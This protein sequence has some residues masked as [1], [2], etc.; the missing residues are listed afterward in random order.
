MVHFGNVYYL[1][2]LYYLR[3]GDFEKMTNLTPELLDGFEKYEEEMKPERKVTMWY[4]LMICYFLKGDFTAALHWIEKKLLKDGIKSDREDIVNKCKL[5]NLLVHYEL[6]DT[7]DFES[8]I[9]KVKHSFKK[10]DHSKELIY[11]VTGLMNT[12]YKKHP[13]S[14]KDFDAALKEFDKIDQ[15][16]NK[17]L[18]YDEIEIWLKSKVERQSMQKIAEQMFCH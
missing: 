17:S 10:V 6:E 16:K 14:R 2:F 18:P 15:S 1:E 12:H 11:L 4:N 13:L 5:F 9:R 7:E 3:K 8:L